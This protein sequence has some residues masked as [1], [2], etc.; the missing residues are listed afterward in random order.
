MSRPETSLPCG[1]PR[2]GRQMMAWKGAYWGNDDIQVAALWL[3]II[4]KERR[5]EK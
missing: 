2:Q 3:D 4:V 1:A 5:N